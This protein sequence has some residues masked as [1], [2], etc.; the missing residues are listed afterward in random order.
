LIRGRIL[1]GLGRFERS[2]MRERKP[3]ER[4]AHRLEPRLVGGNA[5]D[6]KVEV[7]A[8]TADLLSAAHKNNVRDARDNF[9]RATRAIV[10]PHARRQG[11]RNRGLDPSLPVSRKCLSRPALALPFAVTGLRRRICPLLHGSSLVDGWGSC[12]LVARSSV[13]RVPMTTIHFATGF[14]P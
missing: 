3:D 5:R 7:C 1:P 12:H 10:A 9:A 14:Q 6:R 2:K 13:W 4:E 11:A 8:S